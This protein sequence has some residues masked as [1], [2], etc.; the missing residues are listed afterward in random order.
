MA[1]EHVLGGRATMPADAGLLSCRTP[2]Q[3]VLA[4][5]LCRAW[6]A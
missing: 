1:L 4:N 6:E 2:A 3:M 5:D